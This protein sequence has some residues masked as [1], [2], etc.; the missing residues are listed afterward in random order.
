MVD[1]ELILVAKTVIITAE[2]L[3]PEL[4]KVDLVGPTVDAVVLARGGAAPTSCHPLYPLD[5]ESILAYAEQVSDQDSF[6]D[7]LARL[8]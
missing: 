6:T 3:V 8:G 1:V 5:T 2:E 7:Y 4:D